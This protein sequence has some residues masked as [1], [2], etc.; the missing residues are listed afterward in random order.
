[1]RATQSA[2][3]RWSWQ[4]FGKT[5]SEKLEF[6]LADKGLDASKFQ[7]HLAELRKVEAAHQAAA[8]GTLDNMGMSAKATARLCVVCRRSSLTS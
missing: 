4:Q 2:S 6:K 3:P 5:A 7:P 8:S 1:M